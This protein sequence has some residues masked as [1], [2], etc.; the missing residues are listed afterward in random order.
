MEFSFLPA[1]DLRAGDLFSLAGVDCEIVRVRKNKR[2]GIIVDFY[3]LAKPGIY[4]MLIVPLGMK[5]DII[6]IPK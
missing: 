3:V 4:P 2:A 5:L 1:K 6:R